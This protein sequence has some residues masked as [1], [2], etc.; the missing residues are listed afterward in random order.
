MY[1]AG[2]KVKGEKQ[3]MDKEYVQGAQNNKKVYRH[4]VTRLI[5][6]RDL[7]LNSHQ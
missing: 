2:D 3:Y 4:T 5:F 1:V 7:S 6:G